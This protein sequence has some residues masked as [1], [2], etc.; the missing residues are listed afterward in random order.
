[1]RRIMIYT[2]KQIARRLFMDRVFRDAFY[3]ISRNMAPSRDC[4]KISSIISIYT[5]SMASIATVAMA[6]STVPMIP[7]IKPTVVMVSVFPCFLAMAAQMI[8]GMLVRS[9]QHRMPT[10]A[11]TR[12]ATPKP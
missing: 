6:F 3:F 5:G 8:A 4:L 2:A 11:Q 10:M 12:D 9:P 1:M 7:R